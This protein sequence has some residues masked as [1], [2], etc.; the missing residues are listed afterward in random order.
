VGIIANGALVRSGRG[1]HPEAGHII[2]E[3]IQ[4]EALCGCGN[5]GCAEAYLSGKNF[6]KCLSQKWNEEISGEELLARAKANDQRAIEE[7]KSYGRR[8][9]IFL[10]SL[11][12]LYAPEVIIIAGGFSH[13][14]DLF[15]PETR[16][17]L[18]SLLVRRR[19]GVD[20]LPKIQLSEFRSAA[21]LLGSARV[22]QLAL[23]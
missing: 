2:I 23:N 1:L 7:F 5:Y 3:H 9:A 15:L 17:E 11:V 22:T 18:E 19:K 21:G 12:V 14:S 4:K 6:C 16:R 10:A 8:L 20:L 13:S